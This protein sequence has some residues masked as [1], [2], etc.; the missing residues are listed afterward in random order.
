MAPILG[1]RVSG[2]QVLSANSANRDWALVVDRSRVSH[3]AGGDS[4]IDSTTSPILTCLRL[5]LNMLFTGRN[6]F[7]AIAP[8]GNRE[9]SHENQQLRAQEQKR[10]EHPC[11]PAEPF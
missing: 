4:T 7:S 9:L 6:T 5:G 10:T 1:S 11:S 2:A 3:Q 8:P